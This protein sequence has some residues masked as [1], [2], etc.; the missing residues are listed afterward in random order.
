MDETLL[1]TRMRKFDSLLLS[2]HPN[3]HIAMIIPVDIRLPSASSS[4]ASVFPPSFATLTDGNSS[5]IV[6][7][8]LQGTLEVNGIKEH[9]LVGTLSLSDVKFCCLSN[10]T[11]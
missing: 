11:S 1:P 2:H 9:Q 10:V 3:L 7:I 5:E 8:E 4:S 6:L